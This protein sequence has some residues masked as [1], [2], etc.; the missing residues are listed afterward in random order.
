MSN[1]KLIGFNVEIFKNAIKSQT[2]GMTSLRVVELHKQLLSSKKC[3]TQSCHPDRSVAQWRD[4]Q[5]ASSHAG[6]ESPSAVQAF[7]A[8]VKLAPQRRENIA[9]R[10][11]PVSC[12]RCAP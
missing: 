2:L 7:T 9:V 6:A 3:N 4:L 8:R 10:K 5:F 11:D 1:C 12:V